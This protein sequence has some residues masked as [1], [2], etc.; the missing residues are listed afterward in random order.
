M[1]GR[2]AYLEGRDTASAEDR[3]ACAVW[4][5]IR[6]IHRPILWLKTKMPSHGRQ[7]WVCLQVILDAI[8][9]KVAVEACLLDPTTLAS[10][11]VI[12]T[13]DRYLDNTS[14]QW[15][16]CLVVAH[17]PGCVT[18]IAKGISESYPPIGQYVTYPTVHPTT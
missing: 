4:S 6:N 9:Y 2:T 12:A 18:V 1:P 15:F 8:T 10:F 11:S 5:R 7:D 14:T 16:E 17:G 13:T 3:P